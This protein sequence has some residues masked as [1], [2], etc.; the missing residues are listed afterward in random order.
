MAL[1]HWTSSFRRALKS[2]YG[3][4]G[5]NGVE[6]GRSGYLSH[7]FVYISLIQASRRFFD[8]GVQL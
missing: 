4:A 1:E 8:L 7:H 5:V 3:P 2:Y 6:E